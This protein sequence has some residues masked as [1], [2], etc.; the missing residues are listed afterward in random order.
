MITVKQEPDS[1]EH[2]EKTPELGDQKKTA[3]ENSSTFVDVGP[4]GTQPNQSAALQFE[5][6]LQTAPQRDQNAHE[7]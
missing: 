5:E 3:D 4:H 2:R 6:A 1:D 7:Q